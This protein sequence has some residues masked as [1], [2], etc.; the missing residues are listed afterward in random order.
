LLARFQHEGTR[1][2]ATRATLVLDKSVSFLAGALREANFQIVE[3]RDQAT[4]FETR[5][6]MLSHR[7][8]VTRSTSDYLD[9]AP[10]LDCGVLGLD[11]LPKT[12]GETEYEHNPTAQL[13]SRAVAEFGLVSERGGWVLVLHPDGQQVFRRV[14]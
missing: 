9:L 3:L 8:V 1:A 14:D 12:H 2:G 10:V 5:R 11:A 13:I 7:I 6:N 4:D